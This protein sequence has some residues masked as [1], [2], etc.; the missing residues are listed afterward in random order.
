MALASGY[1]PAEQAP[2]F[3]A[4]GT[5]LV[6]NVEIING[7]SGTDSAVFTLWYKK[8]TAPVAVLVA[9]PNRELLA[10]ESCSIQLG[11]DEGLEMD[12]GDT[13]LGKGTFGSYLHFTVNRET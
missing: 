8:H 5:V 7:D 12:K 9:S 13:L 1:L 10:G 11:G 4:D 6:G 3:T 2:I